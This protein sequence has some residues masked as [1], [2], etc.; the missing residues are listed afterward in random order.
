MPAFFRSPNNWP[1]GSYATAMSGEL[2]SAHA[3]TVQNVFGG[4]RLVATQKARIS[5]RPGSRQKVTSGYS[6]SWSEDCG[7]WKRMS[8]SSNQHTNATR[9]CRRNCDLH[10]ASRQRWMMSRGGETC[11]ALFLRFWAT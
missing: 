5:R 6:E 7:S 11:T 10:I 8:E 2:E 1:Q 9:A 4:H 3:L